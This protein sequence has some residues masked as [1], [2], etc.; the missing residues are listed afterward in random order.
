MKITLKIDPETLFL[1]HNIVLQQRQF[2]LTG[3]NSGKSMTIELFEILSKRCISYSTN[4]N[5]KN[6]SVELRFHLAEKLLDLAKTKL[7]ERCLGVYEQNKLEIFKN[8]LHQKLV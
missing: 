7:A 6:R 2:S 1:L 4:A 3:R 5:G 8:D